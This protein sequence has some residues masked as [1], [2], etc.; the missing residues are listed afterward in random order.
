MLFRPQRLFDFETATLL[1]EL[2]SEPQLVLAQASC[3]KPPRAE[4][5]A[6]LVGRLEVTD[7]P[8]LW[9]TLGEPTAGVF[10]LLQ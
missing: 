6:L 9:H 2:A 1:E 3:L 4:E 8:Q 10:W 7:E 5:I